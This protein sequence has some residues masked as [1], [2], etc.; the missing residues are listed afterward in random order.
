MKNPYGA[1]LY[2]EAPEG[3]SAGNENL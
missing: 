1:D 3:V 2:R